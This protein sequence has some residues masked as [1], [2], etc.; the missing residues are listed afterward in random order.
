M[1]ILLTFYY[2]FTTILQWPNLHCQPYPLAPYGGPCTSVPVQEPQPNFLTE[3]AH[4][5]PGHPFL[6]QSTYSHISYHDLLD[7]Q[8]ETIERPGSRSRSMPSGSR[9]AR[10][11]SKGKRKERTTTLDSLVNPYPGALVLPLSQSQ[12]SR[13]IPRSS[14]SKKAKPYDNPQQDLEF[15]TFNNVIWDLAKSWFVL[16]LWRESCFFLKA[17]DKKATVDRC[18]TE[19]YEAAISQYSDPYN[20]YPNA[21]AI[22]TKYR[23][24][25]Q[26]TEALV[27]CREVVRS[28][29]HNFNGF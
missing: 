10:G 22:V 24:Q 26:G 12:P 25:P 27:K 17:E 11:R 20:S 1:F 16:K 23:L 14:S 7:S 2:K 18:A 29:Y 28:Y 19:A 6:A 5:P 4:C 15:K 3:S 13:S 8:R 21:A 9:G